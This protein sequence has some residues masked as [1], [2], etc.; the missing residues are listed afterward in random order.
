M[1]GER[2]QEPGKPRES[3][4][5]DLRDFFREE[6]GKPEIVYGKKA[7]RPKPEIK[8]KA[9]AAWGKLRAASGDKKSW[10]MQ[11]VSENLEK[12]KTEQPSRATMLERNRFTVNHD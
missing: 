6:E 9:S 7:P 3:Q 1:D 12:R 11:K 8:K 4:I 5:G 2:K 10:V